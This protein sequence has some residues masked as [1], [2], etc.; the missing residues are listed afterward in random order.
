MSDGPV[1]KA[2]DR[3]ALQD[4]GDDLKNCKFTVKDTGR[5]AELNNEDRLIK[6][7]ERCPA[8]LK[9]RWQTKVQEIRN[10]D[11]EPNIEDVRKLVRTTAREK[12]DPVFGG[13]MDLGDRDS[14]RHVNQFKK[15]IQSKRSFGISVHTVPMV[16]IPASEKLYSGGSQ[17]EVS[18]NLF[19]LQSNLK[20]YLCNGTTNWKFV[21]SLKGTRQAKEGL[22]SH[23][24]NYVNISIT[25]IA[26]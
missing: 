25:G 22:K 10:E 23:Q 13:I 18:M 19:S 16:P 9:S 12:T 1:I 14:T 5:L 4:L 3:E 21:I 11:R 24:V 20:C 15:P 7:L 6:I 26:L 2:G 8:F 17:R